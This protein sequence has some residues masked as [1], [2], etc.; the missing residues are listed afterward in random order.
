MAAQ[1]IT[2]WAVT[3]TSAYLHAFCGPLVHQ[4]FQ[5]KNLDRYVY[6]G[7]T[8]AFHSNT[9]VPILDQSGRF[10][11]HVQF[12]GSWENVDGSPKQKAVTV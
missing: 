1:K 11:K 3:G 7:T 5:T 10:W 2:N 8:D 4:L 6:V 12:G 9:A